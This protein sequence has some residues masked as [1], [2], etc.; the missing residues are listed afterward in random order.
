[1]SFM[2][3]RVS[4]LLKR[5]CNQWQRPITKLPM[6]HSDLAKRESTRPQSRRKEME[7]E[8]KREK[9]GGETTTE[10]ILQGWDLDVYTPASLR[11]SRPSR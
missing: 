9:R 2:T 6:C 11:L 3:V 10:D 1:M 5:T 7:K 4:M 8:K